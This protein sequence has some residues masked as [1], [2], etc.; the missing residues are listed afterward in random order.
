MNKHMKFIGRKEEQKAIKYLLSQNGF[1][2]AVV[3]GRRRL[4]KTELLKQC[5][6][7]QGVP[8]I[9]YQCNQE[10]ERSNTNDL[11][12]VIE[13]TLSLS[14]LHFNDFIDAVD[15]VF[16]K[17]MG[18]RVYF[19]I[20]EYPY[21]R[22]LLPSIDSKLQAV[23][24]KYKHESQICFFLCGS[25]VST[26]EDVL[27]ENNPLYRR[28]P[29]SL[30]IK[31]MDYYDSSLFYPSFS[32]EDKVRLYAA[33]GGIPFYNEQI[34]ENLTVTENIILLL[35][36]SF[37]HVADDIVV[38]LKTEMSKINN[39]NAVFSAIA[40]KKAFH[41]S[42]ILAESHIA[43]SSILSDVLDKLVKMDLID[44]VCPI[45]DK[46]GKTKSGYVIK[47]SALRFFYRYIFHNQSARS[48]L[49]DHSFYQEFIKDDFE[50]EFIPKAFETIAKQYLIRRNKRGENEPLLF[51]IGTYWYG[52][53]KEKKNGQFDVVGKTKSGYVF[54]EV[55]FSSNPI[56]EN[57]IREEIEQVKNTALAPV[58]YGFIS[59][60]GF[61]LKKELPY[62]LINLT[63]I[64]Q[65]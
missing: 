57:V 61:E 2:G 20:D 49:D 65:G 43:S 54:Y 27:S 38:N 10:S 6:L 45:N 3:Y 48:V 15:F 46:N 36:G 30:L 1:Q 28:F 19:V 64:Y 22:K 14:H 47:D 9:F 60:S 41:Y 40:E 34:N 4:G 21:I 24:D 50:N 44:Y 56:T 8:C 5:L 17:T 55:K 37:A 31:E 42:D 51:D 58:Q 39:A 11:T 59:R 32:L 12:K 16:E 23:I 7:N 26:M 63:E 18:E 62:I 13:Q 35:S 53:P 29:C 52:N 25:S 33:F